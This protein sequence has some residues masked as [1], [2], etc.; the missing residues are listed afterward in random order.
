MTEQYSDE[1]VR[2]ERHRQRIEQ[3]RENK[4]KQM[5]RRRLMTKAIPFAACILAVFFII[6]GVIQIVRHVSGTRQND[7]ASTE[8]AADSGLMETEEAN[9][10][11]GADAAVIDTGGNE[12]GTL[13]EKAKMQ[14]SQSMK[15]YQ[16]AESSDTV[17]LGDTLQS[18]EPFYSQYAILTDVE[19]DSI[20][21]QR[22]AH[23]RIVPASMTKILTVLTA[24]EHIDETQLD[25][26]F[27][28]TLDITDYAYVNDCSSAGFLEGEEITVR[29][30]L[31]GTILPSGADA[32]VGLAVY[33]AGSEEAFVE[34]MNEKI[35]ELGLSQTTHF[36]N[37]VGIYEED[38]YTTAYDMAMI[39]EAAMDN[40]LCREV[41]SAHT[42]TTSV[43]EQHPEGI[44]LSNLFLRRIEDK[45][46]G[47]R[48]L[49][50]KT[51]YVVQSGHCAVSYAVSE[52]GKGYVCVTA[53]ANSKWRPVE[54]H[55]KLYEMY[56]Q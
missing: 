28:M 39:M 55:A 43:T 51:G 40:E 25:A 16:A 31:Y 26:P 19:N 14:E 6:F 3:M 45:E 48:V 27:T 37:C 23:T 50:A 13:T 2:R 17:Q 9:N 22:N 56:M 35:E 10:G 24:A 11:M 38:H 36:T 20:I 41:M 1:E 42:Y 8:N 47:E 29:D 4:R 5:R 15:S 32:A 7:K 34:L 49:C 18:G 53:D 33:V 30:L 52:G 44:S 46:G 54:D 21:A 12:G